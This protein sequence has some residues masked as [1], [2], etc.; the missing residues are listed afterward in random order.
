M[1]R[2]KSRILAI[3]SQ[4]A[5]GH[6]GL[7][8]ICPGVQA[9]GVDIWPVP[10]VLLSNHPGHSYV[11]GLRIDPDVLRNMIAALDSNGWLSDVKVVLTG[12]MPSVDHVA[13]AA[14]AVDLVKQ[15]SSGATFLCDPIIGDEEEGIYVEETVAAAIA[16]LLIPKADLLLPN[17][18]ELSWLVG[19]AIPSADDAVDAVGSLPVRSAV[20]TSISTSNSGIANLFVRPGHVEIC[21]TTRQSGVPKGTGDFLSGIF[22]A[23]PDLGRASGRLSSL[24]AASLGKP[25]LAII[26]TQSE[27]TTATPAQIEKLR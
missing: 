15:R 14:S 1:T 13:F 26:A 6:V 20:V 4:V 18:F 8:A 12:Y 10:T 9:L 7:S 3:S 23:D 2:S 17:V 22:A 21:K 25:H 27:W 5:A 24:I 11:S 19:R 16:D